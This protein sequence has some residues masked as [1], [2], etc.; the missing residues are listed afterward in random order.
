MWK[1]VC[2][3]Q[4]RDVLA[5][6][7]AHTDGQ[8]DRNIFFFRRS[9]AEHRPIL[10]GQSVDS[11]FFPIAFPPILS[12]KIAGSQCSMPCNRTRFNVNKWNSV[13]V[14]CPSPI[15][16]RFPFRPRN[17]TPRNIERKKKQPASTKVTKKTLEAHR[18]AIQLNLKKGK[19]WS[20]KEKKKKQK[21]KPWN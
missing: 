5:V 19:I 17:V 6:R 15:G 21:R 4:G 8:T 2:R 9:D 10:I 16:T 3:W 14:F 11:N 13:S 7:Y 20:K 12:S 18:F 1:Y